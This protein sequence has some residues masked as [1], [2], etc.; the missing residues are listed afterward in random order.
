MIE[1]MPAVVYKVI[2]YLNEKINIPIIAGGLTESRE[3]IENAIE[4]GA[5]M[6][7]TSKRDLWR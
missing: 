1:V 4:S 5:K 7:S 2:K 3:E 6:V